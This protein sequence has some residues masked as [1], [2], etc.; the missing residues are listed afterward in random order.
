M[1]DKSQVMNKYN[2]ERVLMTAKAAILRFVG[3][4]ASDGTNLTQLFTSYHTP[5]FDE[6]SPKVVGVRG[7]HERIKERRLYVGIKLN[8]VAHY[9][10]IVDDDGKPTSEAT[11][12]FSCSDVPNALDIRLKESRLLGPDRII[13]RDVINVEQALQDTAVYNDELCITPEAGFDAG[14]PTCVAIITICLKKIDNLAQAR[15]D[16]ETAEQS[17]RK[18]RTWADKTESTDHVL[19]L[20]VEVADKL[21]AAA[22]EV[23]KIHPLIDL[24]WKAST[25]LYRVVSHQFKTDAEL[26]DLIDNMRRAFDFSAEARR[27]NDKADM[28]KPIIK[29]LL[30]V[31]V[32][33]SRFVKE[34]TEH[35]FLGRMIRMVNG[36]RIDEYKARFAVLRE[37]LDSAIGYNVAHV[38]DEI[39]LQQQLDVLL[40]PIKSDASDL[41]IR[42]RCLKGTRK[43]YLDS[44]MK[45]LFSEAAPNVLWLT[46]AAGSGKS[47]IAATAVDKCGDKGLQ[48][49]Y[50]F[51][52]RERNEYRSLIRTIAYKLAL[53]SPSISRRISMA[54]SEN[55]NVIGSVPKK[56][57]EELLLKP[58][59]GS[60]DEVT[61]PIV[62]ILDALDECGSISQRRDLLRL[63]QT[64][65]AQLPAKVRILITSRPERDVMLGISSKNHIRHV[66]LRHTSRN[67]KLDVDLYIRKELKDALDEP[68]QRI[69]GWDEKMR[70][71][72]L[73][74]GGLFIWASTV[75][76][77]VQNSDNPRRQLEKLLDNIPAV[78]TSGVDVLYAGALSESG[79]SWDDAESRNRFTRVMGVILIAKEAMSDNVIESFLGLESGMGRL[80]LGS[81]RSVLFYRPRKP[82]HVHHASFADYL[83]SRER[84]GG[85]PWHIDEYHQK[86]ALTELCLGIMAKGLRF[87][88]CNIRTSYIRNKEVPGLQERVKQRIHPHLEYACRYWSVH[89]CEVSQSFISTTLLDQLKVFANFH[90]LYWLEVLSLTGNFNRVAARALYE[91]SLWTSPIDSEISS[92]LWAGYRLASVFAYPISESVPHIYLSAISLWKGE[93]LIADRYSRTHPVVRAHRSGTRVPTQC[94]KVFEGPGSTV[95]SVTFSPDGRRI[96]S[97]CRGA[98]IHIWDA[99]TGEL[100]AGPINGH[101]GEV[102]S[103]AFSPVGKYIA[104]GSRDATVRV[105]DSTTGKL[106]SGPF[107]GHEDAVTSV[108][109]SVDGKRVVSGSDD[110]T[111]R[112]W[113]VR[114]G[115]IVSDPYRG[116]TDRVTSVMFSPN[117]KHVVSGS[118]DKTIH[119]WSVETGKLVSGPFEGHTKAVMSVAVSPD[120]KHIV[121]G[122]LDKTIRVWNAYGRRHVLNTFKGHMDGVMSVAYSRDGKFIVSG[123]QDRTAGVWDAESGEITSGPFKGHSL[124]VQSVAFSSDGKRVISGSTDTTIRMWDC[125]DD[126]HNSGPL[127]GHTESVLSVAFSTDGKSVVSGSRD[128]SVRVWDIASRDLSLG[129]LRGHASWVMSMT[130]WSDGKHIVS[131]A[132]DKKIRVWD[133]ETGRS[134]SGTIEN[135]DAVTAVAFTPKNGRR[136]VSVS[137]DGS[138]RVWDVGS[139]K[140]VTGPFH[141]HR[142]WV[143]SIAISPN[144]KR[145]ASGSGDK[146]ICIWD[147]DS[148]RLVAGPFRGHTCAVRCVT[149]SPSGRF[150][151]S[152]SNDGTVRIW[153]A[154]NGKLVLNPVKEHTEFITSIAFSA[155]G[156]RIVSG[157]NDTSICIWDSNTGK[158][159]A[160]PLRGH[161]ERVTSVAF[162]PDGNHIV[163]GSDDR[164][165]RIWNVNSDEVKTDNAG[166]GRGNIPPGSSRSRSARAGRG[167]GPNDRQATKNIRKHENFSN[168]TLSEDGWVT[169]EQGELLTW[170][171]KDMQRSLLLPRSP[172]ILSCDFLMSLDFA[173]SPVGK[174]WSRGYDLRDQ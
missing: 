142:G 104:S 38:T 27:L 60:E 106:A 10:G 2:L 136:V 89:L 149:F 80:T 128:R 43:E 141:G 62:I 116:H 129:P 98:A 110:S 28:L 73:A 114:S 46:G 69:E 48:P 94:I 47:A 120:G 143:S 109:F 67:S 58:L 72:S 113:D 79:I 154:N 124:C 32:E 85:R 42:P 145:F 131:G 26:I 54:I 105:W 40:E 86:Q 25:V 59:C 152:G 29:K 130:Y 13:G 53:R 134:A 1:S 81:L 66:E 146:T 156:K 82:V 102:W 57:F 84:S 68:V 138:I 9:T 74:A 121:S 164:T 168:W 37:D 88:I 71:L 151:A 112:V 159:V 12:T 77:M 75:V 34:Y 92:L 100:V 115:S 153:N 39:Q 97:G 99:Y 165:V 96:V 18:I 14:S 137:R 158:L 95:T 70:R 41:S 173:T 123:S 118:R 7:V 56:Q 76:K 16:V 30:D 24:S 135:T 35:K 61:G 44:I 144:G 15:V 5:K 36:Y 127:K 17:L 139:G 19:G 64:D 20:V 8:Q 150:V 148:A 101:R 117:G 91:A 169:G 22:D 171:P 108:S 83:L 172:V 155:D 21:L 132:S 107:E 162:S 3:K 49:T 133:V 23:V 78:G 103:V 174:N 45:F 31:T 55:K 166:K 6:A 170:V 125:S 167:A 51:F 87:N 126:N 50:L 52:E 93:S 11:F 4:R 119:L 63:L 157:S 90:L 65:V 161:G 122:S 140:L 33:C 163:S 160:G 111:I 147:T